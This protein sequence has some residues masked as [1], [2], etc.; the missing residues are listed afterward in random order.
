MMPTP[1]IL[2]IEIDM[3]ELESKTLATTLYVSLFG[4]APDTGGLAYWTE[5]LQ[6]GLSLQDT[7]GY[8]LSSDEGKALYGASSSASTFISSLYQNALNRTTDAGSSEF[9]QGRLS[10]LGSRNEMVEQFINSIQG[11]SGADKQLLTNKIDFGLSFSASKSGDSAIYAKILLAN[12]TSDPASLNLAKLVNEYVDNPPVVVAPVV[13]PVIPSLP[14]T[15]TLTAPTIS[16]HEDTGR[17]QADGITQNGT[18]DVLL[19]GGAASW[20]YSID[21]GTNWL[22]GSGTSFVLG[23]KT[24][25]AG[26]VLVK[27]LNGTGD[28]SFNAS[29]VGSVVIDQTGP[30]YKQLSTAVLPA[31]PPFFEE[32]G[33]LLVDF[34]ETVYTGSAPGF[35]AFGYTGA[36][37]S[38]AG[39]QNKGVIDGHLTIDASYGMFGASL[40]LVLPVG[41]VTDAAGNQSQALDVSA[42]ITFQLI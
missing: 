38:S 16:L 17:S 6:G 34:N 20:Q 29:F 5:K 14:P 1:R 24:Y 21:A 33:R 37:S 31:G 41:I 10:E 2:P 12:V 22:T 26:D 35:I 19:P 36:P 11:G 25:A 39:M 7:I 18:V 42:G 40:N 3:T 27:Y 13:P 15:P 23:E 8:F 9:W 32:A 4:R 28:L 30:V